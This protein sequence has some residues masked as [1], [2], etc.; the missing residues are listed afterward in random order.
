MRLLEEYNEGDCTILY[1]ALRRF[2]EELLE[3]GG[4]LAYTI[5]STAMRLFRSRFLRHDIEIGDAV[6]K[7]ARAAYV[8]SRVEVFR[9]ESG[10][11]RGYDINSSFPHSMSSPLPGNPI[12]TGKALNLGGRLYLADVKVTVPKSYLPPLPVRHADGRIFFPV[13]SWRQWYTSDDLELLLAEGGRID[14]VFHSI[15]F[16]PFTDLA[17]Y[18]KVIYGLRETEKDEFRRLVY[19]YLLNSLYGKFAERETKEYMVINPERTDTLDSDGKPLLRMISPGVFLGEQEVNNSHSHVPIA[20]FITARSRALL[21]RYLKAATSR[22]RVWYCDTDSIYTDI[23]M[24]TTTGLG[25]LKLEY[26]YDSATFLAPKLYALEGAVKG[27]EGKPKGKVK[28][29]GFTG[30]DV[31]QFAAMAGE[32]LGGV[33]FRDRTAHRIRRMLRYKELCNAGESCPCEVQTIKRMALMGRPKRADAGDDTRPWT[34]REIGETW[35][36][37]V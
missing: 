28:A 34:V 11:G 36:P 27:G 24:A 20:A 14:K 32:V 17:D 15:E 8:A 23:R 31:M 21:F 29:K 2:E 18:V 30:L 12:R 22:G 26:C 19:K 10:P 5:A 9:R 13:G 25:G 3:L 7:A 4:S 37:K 33:D 16:E 6:N 1:Q 35:M